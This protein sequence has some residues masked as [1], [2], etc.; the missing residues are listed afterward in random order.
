MILKTVIEATSERRS[1]AQLHVNHVRTLAVNSTLHVNH[2]RTLAANSM[3]IIYA[4]VQG[5]H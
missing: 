1:G 2:V 5:P 4:S 3:N